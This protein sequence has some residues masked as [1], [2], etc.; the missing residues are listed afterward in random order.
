MVVNTKQV[1][2]PVCGQYAEVHDLGRAGLTPDE[3]L[4][5]RQ[6]I[7]EGVLGKMLTIAELVSRRMDP[8]STS[9]ELTINEALEDFSLRQVDKLDQV[10]RT[11]G[12]ISEKIVGTGIGEVSEIIAAQE[13]MQTF[14]KDE[15][16][17]SQADK[18][19]TDIVATVLDKKTEVGKISISI[20]NTKSWKNE[21]IQ[22]LEK[23]TSHDSAKV[24]ILISKTLPRRANPKGE[25]I[26]NNGR[27]FFLVGPEYGIPIYAALRHVVINIHNT[28]QYLDSKEKELTQIS[29]IS[30]ALAKWITGNE[31]AEVLKTLQ[32]IHEHSGKSSEE[33]LGMADYVEKKVK[34][35]CDKQTSIQRELLNTEGFLSG[36]KELLT[37][38]NSEEKN[39]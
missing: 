13:F 17:T 3:L 30:K 8:N 32:K 18:H 25:V 23:N 19:G 1:E 4:K 14:P 2:C 21:F 33:L 28:R 29:K 15:F 24:G 27:M 12:G 31:Y 16:D 34:R 36:L 39:Q 26:H 9:M 7:K 10:L 38:S 6:Y 5:I 11:L 35:D 37:Q 20:K 22:Q